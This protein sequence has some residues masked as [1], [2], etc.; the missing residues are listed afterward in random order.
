[1]MDVISARN[2][3]DEVEQQLSTIQ[4]KIQIILNSNMNREIDWSSVKK[5]LFDVEFT[6]LSGDWG[7][8]YEAYQRPLIAL[9]DTLL[10]MINETPPERPESAFTQSRN[11]FYL[12]RLMTG[13]YTSSS[14]PSNVFQNI[15]RK[16]NN[17][18]PIESNETNLPLF[19]NVREKCC[20]Q[21]MCYICLLSF[22]F[23]DNNE[24]TYLVCKHRFHNKCIKQWV[25]RNNTTCPVCKNDINTV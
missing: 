11:D 10:R 18:I 2:G 3:E 16:R 23:I 24:P 13:E 5:D 21:E 1:M 20:T 8:Y 4:N 6:I 9:V 12:N 22:T 14:I 25:Y 7:G 17:Q 19:M 15:I